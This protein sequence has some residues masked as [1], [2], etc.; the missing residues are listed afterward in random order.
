MKMRWAGLAL[1][2][3]AAAAR[4]AECPLPLDVKWTHL[5]GEW[6]A[7]ITNVPGVVTVQ[8]QEHPEDEGRLSG[9]VDRNGAKS[10]LAAEVE[11]GE[12]VMEESADGTHISGSWVGDIVAGSCGREIRGTYRPEDDT[13]ERP[14][15]LRRR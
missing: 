7:E 1:L 14:F 11:K 10:R 6:R 9:R 3:V 2:L 12:F 8:L 15:V 5:V 13:P 4:A